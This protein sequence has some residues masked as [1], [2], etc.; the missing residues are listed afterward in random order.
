MKIG[1]FIQGLNF[2]ISKGKTAKAISVLSDVQDQFDDDVRQE[3]RMLS[4]RFSN[5]E[6]KRAE[7]KDFSIELNVINNALLSF[8]AELKD[9][10]PVSIRYRPSTVYLQHTVF[11]SKKQKNYLK[12][13]AGFTT[14]LL[15]ITV[16]GLL[17]YLPSKENVAS[18]SIKSSEAR[19]ALL[20]GAAPT[21]ELILLAMEEFTFSGTGTVSNQEAGKILH[22][23]SE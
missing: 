12:W 10:H 18:G 14:I 15:L 19:D 9:Y 1:I 13:A 4:S 3:F 16:L 23:W 7:Q 20:N 17:N 2:L 21:Q 6:S 11:K 5:W 22:Y 8:V